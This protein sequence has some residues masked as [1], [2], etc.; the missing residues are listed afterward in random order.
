MVAH[1]PPHISGNK[2]AIAALM[3]GLLFL[4][5][6]FNFFTSV[7]SIYLGLKALREIRAR[8]MRN[9]IGKVVSSAAIILGIIPYYLSVIYMLRT[10]FSLSVN[11]LGL[12]IT[13]LLPAIFTSTFGFLKL[14]RLI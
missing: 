11:S 12:I 7:I 1:N 4:M 14:R 3:V 2:T 10:Y 8:G 13:L 9:R 5:P 6:L